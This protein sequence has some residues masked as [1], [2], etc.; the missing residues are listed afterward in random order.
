[1]L[2][3]CF[4]IVWWYFLALKNHKIFWQKEISLLSETRNKKK[5]TTKKHNKK[6]TNG[7]NKAK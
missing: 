6:K 5:A 3:Y 4:L 7:A 2:F 1:M